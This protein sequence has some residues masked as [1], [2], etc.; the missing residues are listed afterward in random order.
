MNQVSFKIT[1]ETKKVVDMGRFLS[2]FDLG[3][4]GISAPVTEIWS[5]TTKTRTDNK[6]ISKMKKVI[7]E[8]CEING[9]KLISV[10]KVNYSMQYPFMTIE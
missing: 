7:K 9:C 4:D 1:Y 8:I 5:W 6:Y 3:L 2:K 10:E